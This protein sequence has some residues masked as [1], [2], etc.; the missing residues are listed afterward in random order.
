MGGEGDCGSAGEPCWV[1]PDSCAAA[2]VG[3]QSLLVAECWRARAVHCTRW[4][5]YSPHPRASA[6]TGARWSLAQARAW[7]VVCSV[8]SV[9]GAIKLTRRLAG[10]ARALEGSGGPCTVSIPSWSAPSCVLQPIDLHPRSPVGLGRGT[11]SSRNP[12]RLR[13]TRLGSQEHSRLTHSA[14]QAARGRPRP[15]AART[16]PAPLLGRPP[17]RGRSLNGSGQMDRAGGRTPAMAPMPGAAPGLP[18][19]LPAAHPLPPAARTLPPRPL[20]AAAL[21]AAQ[22]LRAAQGERR[23]AAVRAGG[24][25][26]G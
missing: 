14:S 9:R 1:S 11:T 17:A 8:R 23:Q 7:R 12:S 6:G 18:P 5:H 19:P 26:L 15:P 20:P 10:L 4:G 16:G 22:A 21:L 25:D 13:P 3:R 24:G 2:A